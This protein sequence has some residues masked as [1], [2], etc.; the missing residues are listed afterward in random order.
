MEG[1]DDEE[2]N[3]LGGMM[4]DNN[5]M[6]LPIRNKMPIKENASS[7]KINCCKESSRWPIFEMEC[8]KPKRELELKSS[9]MCYNPYKNS[10][11]FN[12]YAAPDYNDEDKEENNYIKNN[13]EDKEMAYE[14]KEDV[15]N[16][17]LKPNLQKEE[18]PKKEEKVE[19]NNKELIL[20]QDIFEGFWNLNPQ[21]NLLIEKY[22][23]IYETI[24]KKLNDKN[25]DKE[26]IK[27][28]LLV[29]HY[30]N[31]NSSINKIE[32]SLIMKKGYAFLEKNGINF[33]EFLILLKIK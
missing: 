16:K 25:L 1:A 11:N 26:E 29:L 3:E 30:L 24:E 28:T 17:C 6:M 14:L 23:N 27:V 18:E 13:L 33:E 7:L 12:C 5:N 10:D 31:T 2:I 22:K 21:T 9:N 32:Y 15:L 20:T 8:S 4:A 19:F